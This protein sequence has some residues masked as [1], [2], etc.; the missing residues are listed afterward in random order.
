MQAHKAPRKTHKSTSTLLGQ[1][2]THGSLP[3]AASAPKT[4]EASLLGGGDS[5]VSFTIPIAS[6]K[7]FSL[8]CQNWQWS[9]WFL[10]IFHNP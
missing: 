4:A 6:F 7:H 1:D 9:F 10:Q 3:S 8:K 2:Q 5:G